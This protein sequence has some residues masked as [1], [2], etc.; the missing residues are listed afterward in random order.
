M[1][2]NE[3]YVYQYIREDASPFYIGKRSIMVIPGTESSRF[4][5]RR[6]SWKESI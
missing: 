2:R 3:F 5:T 1:S 4:T 6:T